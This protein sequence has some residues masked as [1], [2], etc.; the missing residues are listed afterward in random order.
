VE[1][2][3]PREVGL[4]EARIELADLVTDAAVR[5]VITYLTNRGRRVAAIVPVLAAEA[6]EHA[7]QEVQQ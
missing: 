3:K 2:N 7:E 6:A 1:H 4:R 5:G